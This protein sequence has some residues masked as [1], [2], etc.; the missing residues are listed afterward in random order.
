MHGNTVDLS[1]HSKCPVFWERRRNWVPTGRV[2]VIRPL[3]PGVGYHKTS[4][5]TRVYTFLRSPVGNRGKKTIF[6]FGAPLTV[7]PICTN[8][9][10]PTLLHPVEQEITESGS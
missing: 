7:S 1:V 5:L 9:D 10:S 8:V 3:S 2:P 4:D 6:L